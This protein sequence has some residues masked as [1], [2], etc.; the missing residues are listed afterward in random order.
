[1]NNFEH[2]KIR[3]AT[4]QDKD[5]IVS[6][7]TKALAE[8][9]LKPEFENA[10]SDLLDVEA[11]YFQTGGFLKIVEDNQ[12]RLLGTFGLFPID[13]DRCKLRKMYLAPHVRGI[14]LGK[15]MLDCAIASAQKLGFKTMI[16]ETMLVMKDA[17]RLY[18]RR[19]FKLIKKQPESPRC[20]LV[21]ALSL[22]RIR[23]QV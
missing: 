15:R 2:V 10:E 12:G 17:V 16:L 21:F 8:F 19:G 20:E 6:L 14:G 7:V 13:R 18:T 23:I 3:S 1:M 4:N 5:R 9:G 11:T 22:A